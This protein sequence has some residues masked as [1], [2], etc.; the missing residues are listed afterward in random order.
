MRKF[1]MP[2]AQ[3]PE[4]DQ[5]KA[6]VHGFDY[7]LD[8]GGRVF[9]YKYNYLD[10]FWNIE[11]VKISARHYLERGTPEVT[12]DVPV[13]VLERPKYAGVL[14]YLQRRYLLIKTKED[15]GYVPQWIEAGLSR[16]KNRKR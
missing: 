5:P 8:K 4:P 3:D 1:G 11:G 16:K 6:I 2:P 13:A 10:Y 15:A 7:M 12:V 14:A 9:E